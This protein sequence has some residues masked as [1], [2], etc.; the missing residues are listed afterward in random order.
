[1]ANWYDDVMLLRDF[2]AAMVEAEAIDDASVILNK[3]YRF[4]SEYLAWKKA[5]YPDSDEDEG[6]DNFINEMNEEEEDAEE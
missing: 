6:W 4:T 5:G 1:M 2:A 3:P